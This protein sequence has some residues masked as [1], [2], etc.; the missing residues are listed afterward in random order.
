MGELR[1]FIDSPNEKYKD[2]VRKLSAASG[3]HRGAF[4]KTLGSINNFDIYHVALKPEFKDRRV[5]IVA[6]IHGDEPGGPWGIVRWLEKGHLPSGLG[7]DIIP[8]A[9]PYGFAKNTRNNQK[10]DMNRQWSKPENLKDENLLIYRAINAVKYDMLL[11]LHEDPGR[12]DGFYLYCSDHEREKTWR[13][14]LRLAEKY[15][16]IYE[17][18]QVYG[19]PVRS[20]LVWHDEFEATKNNHCLETWLLEEKKVPYLTTETSDVF[21]LSKRTRFMTDFVDFVLKNL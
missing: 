15:F 13:Q 20:G 6:G 12:K 8:L 18:K 19:D 1:D 5:L 4:L 9:N 11:T 7:V 21:S 10:Y 2:F 3:R 16:P 17:K 14:C